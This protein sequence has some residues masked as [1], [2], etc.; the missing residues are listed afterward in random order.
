MTVSPLQLIGILLGA[1]LGLFLIWVLITQHN[2][3]KAVIGHLYATFYTS[4]GAKYEA[5]C[6]TD[7]NQVDAPPQ[8]MQALEKAPKSKGKTYFVR[9]DKTFDTLYPP[10]RPSWLQTT[11]HSTAYYEGSPEPIVSRDPK[12][13]LVP[14]G[15]PEVIHNIRD[16]KMTGL[17]VRV[18]EEME[19]FRKAAQGV[20]NPKFV[21]L[22]LIIAAVGAVV[23]IFLAFN[24][25]N[26]ITKLARLWGL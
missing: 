1:A 13:R 15:T 17:M 21:Y 5:L 16:E 23:N 10:G 7:G 14:I 20:V 4:T 3:K 2:T 18:G 22:L 11:V 19:R 8:A 9:E 25:F 26:S 12:N 6:R 24:V